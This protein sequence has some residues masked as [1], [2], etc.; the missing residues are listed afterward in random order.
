M[1]EQYGN[2]PPPRFVRNVTSLGH[3]SHALLKC[4]M[5]TA[6][7]RFLYASAPSFFS[8]SAV[9]FAAASSPSSSSASASSASAILTSSGSGAL[10]EDAAGV[11][12]GGADL[13]GGGGEVGGEEA[14]AAD[15]GTPG[16]TSSEPSG[17]LKP[18]MSRPM[19]A[20]RTSIMRGS[21]LS[22][23]CPSCGFCCTSWSC[24]QK[25]EP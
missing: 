7:S 3:V 25:V 13:A 11:V 24:R 12:G 14:D 22:R 15:V 10:E 18:C 1:R 21:L 16:R 20:P 17:R 23:L 5:A 8:A 19:R 2:H 6:K 4:V 9:D